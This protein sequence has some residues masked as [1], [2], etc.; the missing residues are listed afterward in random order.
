[1]HVVVAVIP[2]LKVGDCRIT[3]EEVCLFFQKIS[4]DEAEDFL[5]YLYEDVGRDVF[6][7]YVQ[8]LIYKVMLRYLRKWE[9]EEEEVREILSECFC[10]I[11]EGL[12]KY[13]RGKGK[14]MSYIYTSVRGAV[15]KYLYSKQKGV[16]RDIEYS[17][18]LFYRNRELEGSEFVVNGNGSK[19]EDE[20]EIEMKVRVWERVKRA[21]FGRMAVN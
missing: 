8:G 21:M 18:A 7:F 6:M 17:D 10:S 4:D 2:E 11:L 15:T 19:E 12:G 20:D 1:M 13:E 3:C 16:F 9:L 14:L 5:R